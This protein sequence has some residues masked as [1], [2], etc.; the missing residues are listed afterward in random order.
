MIE[1]QAPGVR[2]A[3]RAAFARRAERHAVADGAVELP[4]RVRL[5]AAAKPP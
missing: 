2:A 1:A 4:A 5:A 3:I